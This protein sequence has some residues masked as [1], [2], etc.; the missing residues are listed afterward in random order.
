MPPQD[1]PVVLLVEDQKTVMT[2]LVDVFDDAGFEPLQAFGGRSAVEY[3]RTRA[4]IRAVLT[5]I[6][7]PDADG[8]EVARVARSRCPDCPIVVTSGLDQSSLADLPPNVAFVQ[9]PY[10]VFQI[11][12]RF[13]DLLRLPQLSARP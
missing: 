9:K 1:R 6:R 10:D 4:D 7:L 12:A 3:L 8:Y 5:D 2:L 13:G 11:V